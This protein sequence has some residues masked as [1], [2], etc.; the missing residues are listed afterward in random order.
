MANIGYLDIGALQ[1]KDSGSPTSETGYLDIGALQHTA[2][3]P[4][5]DTL[6]WKSPKTQPEIYNYI[7]DIV[8]E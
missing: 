1:H 4:A 7:P 2:S 8:V 3:A 6:L 5:S